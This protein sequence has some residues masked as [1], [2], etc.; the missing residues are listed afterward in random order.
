MLILSSMQLM[1]LSITL[2]NYFEELMK[3]VYSIS[4]LSSN[5]SISNSSINKFSSNSLCSKIYG[6]ND[7]LW[8]LNESLWLCG[9]F[10]FIF[11]IELFLYSA[12]CLGFGSS[13]SVSKFP[14]TLISST[15][16]GSSSVSSSPSSREHS[17]YSSL[18]IFWV[19]FYSTCFIISIGEALLLLLFLKEILSSSGEVSLAFSNNGSSSKEAWSTF[20]GTFL[21]PGVLW[22]SLV[23]FLVWVFTKLGFT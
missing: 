4:S 16:I 3:A 13:T 15:F 1:T 17:T 14:S 19:W 6:P 20:S 9:G 11:K 23:S 7:I 10:K 2:N 12:E 22:R 8:F 21:V 18:I 5:S